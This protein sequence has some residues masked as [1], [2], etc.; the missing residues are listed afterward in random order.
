ME[1]FSEEIL[2]LARETGLT[3]IPVR[4]R[5]QCAFEVVIADTPLMLWVGHYPGFAGKGREDYRWQASLSTDA[6]AD[7]FGLTDQGIRVFL[8]SAL[9]MEPVPVARKA[10]DLKGL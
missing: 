8:A 7:R 2:A 6:K 3:P 9:F 1:N 5:S 10:K 4:G